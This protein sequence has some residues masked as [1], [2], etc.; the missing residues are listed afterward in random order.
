MALF[1]PLLG[2]KRFAEIRIFDGSTPSV[3]VSLLAGGTLIY[4]RQTQM[5]TD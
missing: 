3:V 1:K 5:F 4:S 2:R